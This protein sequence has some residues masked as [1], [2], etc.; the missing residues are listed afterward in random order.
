MNRLKPITTKMKG[1]TFCPECESI[2]DEVLDSEFPQFRCVVCNISFKNE[3]QKQIFVYRNKQNK[4]ANTPKNLPKSI[5][6]VGATTKFKCK[7]CGHDKASFTTMQTRS[8]DE[9][10]TIFFQC[11]RCKKR[12][13]T[14][15]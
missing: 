3:S 11:A 4:T 10:Q 7:A 1:L 8:A 5:E 2:V 13:K 6:E 15:G 14:S 12:T 9:G